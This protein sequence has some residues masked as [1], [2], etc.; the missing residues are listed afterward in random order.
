M[1]FFY[2]TSWAGDVTPTRIVSGQYGQHYRHSITDLIKHVDKTMSLISI[3]CDLHHSVGVILYVDTQRKNE[4]VREKHS[5]FTSSS[6]YVRKNK[7]KYSHFYV[8]FKKRR[9]WQVVNVNK[10]IRSTKP[11]SQRT[12][13]SFPHFNTVYL[14]ATSKF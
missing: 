1:K 2:L 6:S 9:K 4:N 13:A 8:V 3:W 5:A 7:R 11:Q 12:T 10:L 14:F